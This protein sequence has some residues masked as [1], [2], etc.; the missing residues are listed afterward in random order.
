MMTM[1]I[2]ILSSITVYEPNFT[3]YHL[4]IKNQIIHCTMKI[5]CIFLV[6]FFVILFSSCGDDL[7]EIAINIQPSKDLISVYT[8]TFHLS[9]QNVFVDYIYSRPDSF[10][11]GT[12]YDQKYG[13]TQA[14]I[15]AQ[16]NCP[17]G[18]TYPEGSVPDSANIVL[19]YLT[20]F[21]DNYSPV[22]INI[23]QMNKA[24]FSYSQPYPSNIDPA[25]Y[26]DKTIH[27]GK[28]IVTAKDA[29]GSKIDTMM[30]RFKLS[31]DFVRWF[32]PSS[33]KYTS[34]QE[35]L[36]K[37]KGIYITPNFGT[38]TM[39]YIDQID[40][41]YYYHYTYVRKALDG[42]TDSTV[43]VN[44]VITFPANEEVRQ[45][46]RFMHPNREQIIKQREEV[47]YIS[48]PANVFTKINIPLKKIKQKLDNNINDKYLS[49]NSAVL[50]VDATEVEDTT[51]AQPLVKYLLLIKES[52]M[53]RFFK[54]NELPSDTCSILA[55]YSATKNNDNTYNYYYTFN[56]ASLLTNELKTAG[57]NAAELPDQLSFLLVPVRIKYNSSGAVTEVKH[58][59]LMSAVTICSGKH[60]SKPMKMNLV[61][62][63]F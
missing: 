62:S 21:G 18:F 45:V 57:T 4:L 34:Q 22:E 10:L 23:Y 27:L 9:S 51:L 48:S 61:Y 2:N 41:Y 50:Q 28:R 43:T 24:T 60:S 42:I 8:D 47:N 20:W 52:A 36:E 38:A 35:F 29:S 1:L 14:D 54:N 59:F 17:V 53:D 32:Y 6:S 56:L 40:L 15:L 19:R 7:S 3:T 25:D 33:N 5:K 37:F 58:Q 16:V 31:D 12:F 39:F 13:I 55:T 26:T 63:G 49:I 46:N 11:L 30:I 44:N